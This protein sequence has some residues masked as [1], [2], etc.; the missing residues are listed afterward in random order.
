[1]FK[2]I[3]Q[4]PSYEINSHGVIRKISNK[5][6]KYVKENKQ[7]Y[8]YTQFTIKKKIYTIKVHR[9][10]AE[11]FLDPPSESLL[12]ECKAKYPYVVC[13]NHKD[14]NKLNNH[15]ENL[16]WCTHTYNTTHAWKN[17]LIPPLKGSNNGRAKLTEDLVHE[18]CKEF[19]K[20]MQPKEASEVF[21]ISIQQ[22]SKIRCGIA[23]K[24]I[25]EQYR[26]K[27]NKRKSTKTSNDQ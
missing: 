16:E 12:E 2:F 10:V 7:G 4:F 25:S 18:V 1:M 24:H 11:L 5:K 27:V 21:G 23:W 19:E 13:V 26:I 8:L 15:V 14:G 6:V 20:G 17:N 3:P 9:L 22:A